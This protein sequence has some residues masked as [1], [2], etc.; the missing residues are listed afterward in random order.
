MSGR[1]DSLLR[2]ALL[3]LSLAF[4][5]CATASATP[6]PIT[7][8]VPSPPPA[9]SAAAPAP[10]PEADEPFDGATPDDLT[11]SALLLFRHALPGVKVAVVESLTLSLKW[12]QQER[13]VSLDRMWRTCSKEPARCEPATRDFVAKVAGITKAKEHPVTRESVVAALR[14]KEYLDAIPA[15]VRTN[16]LTDPFVGDLIVVY[17]ADFAD[18]ARGLTPTDLTTLGVP[19]AELAALARHNLESRL[20]N[21]DELLAKA[22]PGSPVAI[23][24]GNYYESSRL[25]QSDHW[26]ALAE[27][28]KKPIVVAVPGNDVAFVVLDPSREMLSRLGK[29]A[30]DAFAHA[31]RPISR[32]LYRWSGTG[33]M[34]VG[35]P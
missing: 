24:A 17:M 32:S 31:E 2:F 33:W 35:G 15:A 20:S 21:V 29:I 19:R 10:K 3:A 13:T 16:T 6:P 28:I 7:V 12:D 14:P 34:V 27:K 8:A 1:F 4:F 9:P 18:A 11:Q 22:T 30:G 25:L 26:A 23:A 5:G